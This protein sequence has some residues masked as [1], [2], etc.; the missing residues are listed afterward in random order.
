MWF[1]YVGLFLLMGLVVLTAVGIKQKSRKL[2]TGTFA[3]ILIGGL[4]F[5][6]S[7]EDYQEKRWATL[8]SDLISDEPRVVQ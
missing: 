3:F 7:L 4:S 2:L 8:I 6:A 1:E 5:Y